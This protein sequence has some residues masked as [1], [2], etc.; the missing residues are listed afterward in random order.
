VPIYDSVLKQFSQSVASDAAKRRTASMDVVGA[1][2]PK[3]PVV[4]Q[5]FVDAETGRPIGDYIN[6]C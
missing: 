3:A 6:I 4:R 2:V 5:L 1:G